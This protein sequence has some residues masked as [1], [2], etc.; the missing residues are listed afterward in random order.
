MV[1]KGPRIRASRKSDIPAMTDLLNEIIRAGGSTAMEVQLS[2]DELRYWFVSGPPVL[3]SNV[4]IDDAGATIAFQ[5]VL[6]DKNLPA[7]WG[8]IGTFVKLGSGQRGC[9]RGLFAATVRDAKKQ[10]IATLNATIR[11]DNS[12]GLAFYQKLGFLPYDVKKGVP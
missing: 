11:S 4:A 2:E 6:H 1:L 3:I 5:A 9:G 12:G 10:A 8:D 7:G